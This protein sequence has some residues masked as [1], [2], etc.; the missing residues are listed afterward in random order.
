M[1][2][3]LFDNIFFPFDH[4]SVHFSLPPSL[5][6]LFVHEYILLLSIVLVSNTF[7]QLGVIFRWDVR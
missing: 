5:I 4:G 6:R 2:D 7:S 3:Y 1:I